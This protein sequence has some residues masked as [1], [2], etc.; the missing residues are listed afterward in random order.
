MS[1][2]EKMSEIGK[3]DGLTREAVAETLCVSANK[4]VD[5]VPQLKEIERVI[6]KNRRKDTIQGRL[7]EGVEQEI[8]RPRLLPRPCGRKLIRS[9]TEKTVRRSA[10]ALRL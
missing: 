8:S 9:R 3:S 2:D 5:Y 1:L 10:N 4:P 6:E 7:D